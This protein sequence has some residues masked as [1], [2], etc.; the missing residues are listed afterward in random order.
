MSDPLTFKPVTASNVG[1]F[2]K[3]FGAKGGPNWCWCM[4]F[5]ATAEEIRNS[6]S[7]ERRKQILGRVAR[8]VPIGILAYAAGE[9]VGWVSMAP[10][11]AFGKLGGTAETDGVWSITC[12]F[13]PRARRGQGMAH[14]LIEGAIAYARKR[15]ARL[16]EAYPVDPQS[17]SYRHMGFVPAFAKAGFSEA[18]REGT[19]RHVMQ[20]T[21]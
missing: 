7:P 12:L 21:L 19:R 6:K 18:G 4:A 16:L 15:K 5:R 17:P 1:D 20:L 2:E 8:K 13:V 11:T 14:R 9:P 10:K 3:L